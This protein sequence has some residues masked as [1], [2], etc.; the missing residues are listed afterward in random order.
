MITS[1]ADAPADAPA[2]RTV[3]VSPTHHDRLYRGRTGP[4]VAVQLVGPGAT[5]LTVRIGGK[6]VALWGWQTEAAA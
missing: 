2:V 1:P 3:T 5:L 4:V 6:D